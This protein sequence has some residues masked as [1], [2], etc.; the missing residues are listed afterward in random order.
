M[1]LIF[2]SCSASAKSIS[3]LP[4][5]SN[6]ACFMIHFNHSISVSYL[7]DLSVASYLQQRRFFATV[8]R[9]GGS[10]IVRL[11]DD[12]V[13]ALRSSFK[14]THVRRKSPR[15]TREIRAD[16]QG[17]AKSLVKRILAD[18]AARCHD[19]LYSCNI[20]LSRLHR[21]SA[22]S[23]FNEARGSRETRVNKR[24]LHKRA[25]SPTFPIHRM[26]R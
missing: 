23:I 1:R 20:S 19:D 11:N 6:P 7:N 13:R 17:S 3:R 9:C 22:A 8:A 16:V 5:F 4:S 25:L 2:S 26:Q 14:N 10:V 21:D 18:I 15:V 24:K 12:G